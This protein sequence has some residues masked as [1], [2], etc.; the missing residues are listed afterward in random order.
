[1]IAAV[2][3]VLPWS[4][5]PIVPTLTWGFVRSNFFF[6]IVSS[7]EAVSSANYVRQ[8]C[9]FAMTQVNYPSNRYYAQHD[10]GHKSLITCVSEA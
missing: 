6:A 2:S 10:K 8:G 5:C 3:V 4:M 1:V 7:L 9:T